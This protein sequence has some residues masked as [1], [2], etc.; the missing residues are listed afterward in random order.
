MH[1]VFNFVAPYGYLIPIVYLF[2]A[3]IA[4]PDLFVCGCRTWICLDITRF[5]EER[6]QP[7]SRSA[8]L[9]CQ[10]KVYRA[11]NAGGGRFRHNLQNSL[12]NRCD[13]STACKHD[14]NRWWNCDMH[15]SLLANVPYS[16]QSHFISHTHIYN[17]N[18]YLPL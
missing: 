8:W 2:M 1:S 9:V 11:S 3:Y 13:S 15:Y 17:I 7:S 12:F 10:K 4:N 14:S 18:S 16:V 5:Y 6:R